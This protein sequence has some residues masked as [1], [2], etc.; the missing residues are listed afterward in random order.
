MLT[1]LQ[2]RETLIR[3]R[4]DSPFEQN[5]RHRTSKQE[6]EGLRTRKLPYLCLSRPRPFPLLSSPLSLPPF[7]P[8]TTH[9]R[10]K[11]NTAQR[12]R[13]LSLLLP[14]TAHVTRVPTPPLP[15]S[16]APPPYSFPILPPLLVPPLPPPRPLPCCIPVSFTSPFPPAPSAL[17]SLPSPPLSPPPPSP[18]LS[19]LPL[20]TPSASSISLLLSLPSSSTSLLPSSPTLS[21]FST[22]F[23]PHPFC[24]L[25]S[26]PSS[27]TLLLLHSPSSL[28]P[29][30][31]LLL[32]SPS[33]LT[34]LCLLHSPSPAFSTPPSSLPPPL[35]LP[36][37]PSSHPFCL[38]HSPPPSP[39]LSTLPSTPLSLP[40]PPSAFSTPPLPPPPLLPSPLPLLPFLPH[41]FC[42]LHSPS[43]LTPH[44]STPPSSL[45]PHPAFSTPPPPFSPTPS[46]SSTPPPPFLPPLSAFSTPP[47]PLPPPPLLPL[48]PPTHNHLPLTHLRPLDSLLLSPRYH[49]L[50]PLPPPA[51]CTTLISPFLPPLLITSLLFLTF[52]TSGYSHL[53]SLIIFSYITLSALSSSSFCPCSLHRVI[54][55]FSSSS[56]IIPT[57]VLLSSLPDHLLPHALC[58]SLSSLSSL[59]SSSSNAL[60]LA[61]FS[62]SLCVASL[63]PSFSLLIASFP[64]PP[65]ITHHPPP[66]SPSPFPAT[67][68]FCSSLTVFP[69]KFVPVFL[70]F[71]LF[72]CSL[73]SPSSPLR[74]PLHPSLPPS[75][76]PRPLTKLIFLRISPAPSAS[77]LSLTP[78]FLSSPPPSLSVLLLL[79]H[80][81]ALLPHSLVLSLPPAPFS[82]P[83]LPLQPPPRPLPSALVSLPPP[84][85]PPPPST[86]THSGRLLCQDAR[87]QSLAPL[88]PPSPFLPSFPPLPFSFSLLL[89]PRPLSLSPLSLF[90]DM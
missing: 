60:D 44:P 42:L 1:H 86:Q 32:H 81:P 66:P 11:R 38:L 27:P 40:P 28:L 49:R 23:L 53:R 67:Y 79:V 5:R 35:Q 65:Y 10:I 72:D 88:L 55:S 8:A 54:I 87:S 62:A 9:T 34:P 48:R 22:P 71:C 68:V 12:P 51:L 33:S 16:F 47:P 25:H 39:S 83:H 2:G 57:Y 14:S 58:A 3:G 78:A 56:F 24:L 6:N 80:H 84:G 61:S 26:P 19:L 29:P 64:H 31:F 4:N 59:A 85:L 63:S 74:R 13:P 18:P 76:S 20:P 17:L 41:P 69:F 7:P 43:S 90:L 73:L 82:Y 46:A 37:L 21:A 52:L 75:F 15:A 30:P 45:P 89:L 70:G 36:L 77:P 50:P